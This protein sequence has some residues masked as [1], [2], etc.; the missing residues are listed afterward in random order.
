M[1]CG[2]KMQVAMSEFNA[3]VGL[4]RDV[5]VVRDHQDGVTR[6]VQLAED[7]DDDSFVGFVEITGRFVGKNEPR[8]VNQCARNGHALLF[9]AGELRWQMHQ[10]V[11]KTDA[12]QRLFGFFLVRDAVKVLSQHHV[13]DRREIRHE[14]KLLKNETHFLRTV[15]NQV[16][17]A[18]LRQIHAVNGY[19]PA[20]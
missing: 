1:N 4:P 10:A 8:V 9:A 7:F 16:V 5:R 18:E 3:A 11:A 13:F 15:A 17:F 20:S 12:L 2:V 19:L 14:M 6:M